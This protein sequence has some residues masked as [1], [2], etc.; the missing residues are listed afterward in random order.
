MWSQLV[1]TIVGLW[2]MA[3]PGVLG[4]ERPAATSDWI[5][6]P[7]IATFACIAIWEC[8]RSVKWLNAPLGAWL[9][10]A[11]WLL[12]YP[13]E[14]LIN[15]CVVGAVVITLACLGGRTSEQFGGGWLAL[16]RRSDSRSA[17][18]SVS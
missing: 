13:M 7:L 14:A 5:A 6:G 11:P 15:S 17:Q 2:L 1:S 4:Y 9:L 18:A 3:A 16:W 8:T 12:G 10:I